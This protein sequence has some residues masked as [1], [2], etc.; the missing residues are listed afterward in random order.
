[1]ISGE[2]EV[3]QVKDSGDKLAGLSNMTLGKSNGLERQLELLKAIRIIVP[4]AVVA[5]PSPGALAEIPVLSLISKMEM[6]P[7]FWRRASHEVVEY[8]K[9]ALPRRDRRH[10]VA[11]KIVVKS[12]NAAQTAFLGKL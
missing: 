6:L 5:R 7:L 10:P 2:L 4:D 3:A 8:M 1:M 12:F 9:V 11:L